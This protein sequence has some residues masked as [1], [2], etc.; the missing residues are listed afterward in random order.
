MTPAIESGEQQGVPTGSH[1]T[2]FK[3]VSL[4][5][6]QGSSRIVYPNSPRCWFQVEKV[7]KS[8]GVWGEVF[9]HFSYNKAIPCS[10]LCWA[11]RVVNTLSDLAV[12]T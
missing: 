4:I 7:T 12:E 2:N 6:L 3:V 5:C 1:R 10:L 9:F 11:V 8:A